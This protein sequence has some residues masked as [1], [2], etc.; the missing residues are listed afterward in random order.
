MRDTT[1][2]LRTTAAVCLVTNAVLSAVSVVTQPALHSGGVSRLA[3]LEAAAPRS[4][5][6]GVTFVLAQLPFILAVLGIAWLVWDKAPRLARVGAALGVIG[7]FGHA[8]I[9]GVLLSEV[10]MASDAT[11]RS[12]LG[13]FDTILESS[14]V[15]VF[16][17]LGLAGTVL[18]LLLLSIGLFRS[19]VV[20]VWTPV[21]V[22][23]FL[24]LEFAG[25]AVSQYASYVAVVALTGAFVLLARV[26]WPEREVDA[27]APHSPAQ[28]S[29]AVRTT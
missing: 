7:G 21:L 8:V 15:M 13:A 27:A 14:P 10:V 25:G 26:L 11:H 6:A 2:S 17:L 20:P 5:I 28:A 24:L 23:V 4:A 29:G 12:A 3:E 1:R 9:G 18:G 22:W 16:S 19:R